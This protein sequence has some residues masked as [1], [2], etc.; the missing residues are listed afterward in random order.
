MKTEMRFYW[1]LHI[2]SSNPA[3]IKK[4]NKLTTNNEL[5][6]LKMYSYQK[7]SYSLK[8]TTTNV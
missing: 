3:N 8:N 1:N 5:Q 2:S 4:G 6:K 7:Q